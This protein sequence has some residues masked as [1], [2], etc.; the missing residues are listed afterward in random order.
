[1]PGPFENDVITAKHEKGSVNLSQ[2][3][4]D[5]IPEIC[6]PDKIDA[7]EERPQFRVCWVKAFFAG[8]QHSDWQG[9]PRKP[10]KGAKICFQLKR[11]VLAEAKHRD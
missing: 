4:K 9:F 11:P 8:V 2:A 1:L 10:E 6:F 7:R 3:S 5:L